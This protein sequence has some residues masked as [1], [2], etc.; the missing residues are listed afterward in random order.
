VVVGDL[1]DRA[2]LEN[3]SVMPIALSCEQPFARRERSSRPGPFAVDAEKRHRHPDPLDHPR[4]FL[5]KMRRLG[6]E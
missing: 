3:G 6:I 5:K 1:R 2:K 4:G